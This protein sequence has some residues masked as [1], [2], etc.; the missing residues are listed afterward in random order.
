[1]DA[2]TCNINMLEQ[3][4]GYGI[5]DWKKPE[6]GILPGQYTLIRQSNLFS[7]APVIC[8]FRRAG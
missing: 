5:T 3:P 2:G 7:S 6:T 4:E 8:A 1:M